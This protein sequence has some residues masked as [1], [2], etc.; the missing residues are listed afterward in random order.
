MSS[1][2]FNLSESLLNISAKDGY[3]SLHFIDLNLDSSFITFVLL[4]TAS[5]KNSV[6]GSLVAIVAFRCLFLTIW[7]TQTKH[8]AFLVKHIEVLGKC[9]DI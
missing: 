5:G 7:W 1:P 9:S 8:I 6:S 2:R 3:C 4:P